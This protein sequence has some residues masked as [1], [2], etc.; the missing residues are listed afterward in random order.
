[1]NTQNLSQVGKTVVFS[2]GVYLMACVALIS[3][4]PMGSLWIGVL[5]FSFFEV[6][7]FLIITFFGLVLI[8]RRWP[9]SG[10]QRIYLRLVIGITSTVVIGTLTSLLSREFAQTLLSAY[11]F[12]MI[13]W[14]FLG[15]LLNAALI[16]ALLIA[17]LLFIP[18]DVKISIRSEGIHEHG[19]FVEL[20]EANYGLVDHPMPGTYPMGCMVPPYPLKWILLV[21]LQ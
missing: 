9:N 1:M 10:A 4:P 16:F 8:N 12:C 17:G 20:L 14:A 21:R 3:F 2:L 13:V 6:V 18:F 19:V 7:V 5:Y 15:R 11:A